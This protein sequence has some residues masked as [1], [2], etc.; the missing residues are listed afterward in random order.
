MEENA[1]E[2]DD[3]HIDGVSSSSQGDIMSNPYTNPVI[4]KRLRTLM[5]PMHFFA[6]IQWLS[7]HPAANP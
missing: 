4:L 6:L 7:E 3:V 1:V 2:P 5:L